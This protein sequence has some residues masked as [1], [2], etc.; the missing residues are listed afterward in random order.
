MFAT[1]A[2]ESGASTAFSALHKQYVTNLY[3]RMLRN[4]LNWNV[5][6]DLWRADAQRIRADFEH[7]RNVTN[8]R[9]LAALLQRAEAHLENYA[10]PDPY[11]PPTYVEGTKWERNLPPRLFTDEEK[12]E[13]LKDQHV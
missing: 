1:V 7:N 10:H 12:A 4:S 5:R 6:R 3:R 8:P 13:S 2:R 11:K 9:E